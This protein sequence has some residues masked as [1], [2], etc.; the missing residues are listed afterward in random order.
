M[1]PMT[2]A[3][4]LAVLYLGLRRN[5]ST[6]AAS[7]SMLGSETHEVLNKIDQTISE[8]S[9]IKHIS[10]N[11]NHLSYLNINQINS[12]IFMSAPSPGN[13]EPMEVDTSILNNSDR[14]STKAVERTF[15][16][17]AQLP[18]DQV[19][20]ATTPYKGPS[21]EGFEY[22]QEDLLYVTLLVIRIC[23]KTQDLSE[24]QLQQWSAEGL[25]SSL[26]LEVLTGVANNS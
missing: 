9:A 24:A 8:N 1:K 3:V 17:T 2:M 10:Q 25:S 18:E 6:S 20:L 26:W 12:N 14:I 5:G 4:L 15:D 13:N 23:S 11:Q 21:G 22:L 7:S 16:I 19:P